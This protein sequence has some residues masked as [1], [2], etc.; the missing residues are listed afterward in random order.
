M[1]EDPD[2][3]VVDPNL[4]VHGTTNLYVAGGASFVTCGAAHPT[5]SIVAL[6][7]RLADHLTGEI[8]LSA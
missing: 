3:S 7:L 1:G 2:T 5:L 6:A 4:R 8:R